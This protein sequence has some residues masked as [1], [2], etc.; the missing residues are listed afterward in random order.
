MT[1]GGHNSQFRFAGPFGAKAPPTADKT[2][3]SMPLLRIL[4]LLCCFWLGADFCCLLA[5]I[6][7]RSYGPTVATLGTLFG[8]A[9][10]VLIL[11]RSANRLLC[12]LF[13]DPRLFQAKY[14]TVIIA[15]LVLAVI[16]ALN[17]KAK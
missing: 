1:Y 15:L 7:L 2:R 8:G 10:G 11:P 5:K 16:G 3:Q 6:A 17:L 13:K 14:L 4:I 9:L 12:R